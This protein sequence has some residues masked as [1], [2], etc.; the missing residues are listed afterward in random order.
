MLSFHCFIYIGVNCFVL[1]SGWYSIRLKP[2]SVVNLW[3][4]CFFYAV[5]CF[6]EVAFFS[7]HSHADMLSWK[8]IAPVLLPFSLSPFWFIQCYVALLL[9][10]P[11]CSTVPSA[12]SAASAS[13]WSSCWPLSS[14]SGSDSS[15]AWTP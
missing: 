1:L 7:P 15:G 6:V 11:P 5:A 12:P 4:V 2:R 10:F 14:T 13:Y 3:S 8:Y 9:L